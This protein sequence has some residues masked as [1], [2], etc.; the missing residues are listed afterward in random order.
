MAVLCICIDGSN[1]QVMLP[2]PVLGVGMIHV[3]P[4]GTCVARIM[5][6]AINTDTDR[7]LDVATDFSFVY[8][9]SL[10]RT[11]T[12]RSFMLCRFLVASISY[13]ECHRDFDRHDHDDD[14]HEDS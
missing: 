10:S 3:G 7:P 13:P 9:S 6:S 1:A 11:E 8:S 12:M 14:Q 4:C 5:A 2:L